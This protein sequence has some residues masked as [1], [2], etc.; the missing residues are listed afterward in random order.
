MRRPL[1][2]FLLLLAVPFRGFAQ[3]SDREFLTE[4]LFSAR[5]AIH[6]NNAPY[7]EVGGYLQFTHD[8]GKDRPASWFGPFLSVDNSFNRM[9]ENNGKKIYGWRAG[10]EY[11]MAYPWGFRLSVT[12]HRAGGFQALRLC[13]EAGLSLYCFHLYVGYNIPLNHARL[14]RNTG[15][16]LTLIM[17]LPLFVDDV[18]HRSKPEPKSPAASWL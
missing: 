1:L 18:Y 4:I 5:G 2:F 7:Y 10:M 6:I 13:P 16:Q 11:N 8:N 14:I 15:P 12:G 3:D 17:G 9:S